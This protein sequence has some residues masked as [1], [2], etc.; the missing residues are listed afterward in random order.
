[1]NF[2]IMIMILVSTFHLSAFANC[3]T[4]STT[5][6]VSNIRRTHINVYAHKYGNQIAIHVCNNQ[7]CNTILKGTKSQLCENEK[8]TGRVKV[9]FRDI[10]RGVASGG[11]DSAAFALSKM[12]KQL[13]LDPECP[14]TEILERAANRQNVNN[15]VITYF[16]V[17]G[18]Y[19]LVPNFRRL[20]N[21]ATYDEERI[22]QAINFFSNRVSSDFIPDRN[23][24]S[25]PS[26]YLP[27]LT[28]TT[29][30]SII[31][32]YCAIF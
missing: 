27:N 17:A 24:A 3:L 31:T 18:Q 10:L 25:T 22:Q 15:E 4:D 11:A 1:M 14:A 30:E 7:S 16:E 23:L 9:A 2:Q 12:V 21:V 5:G 26:P 13:R 6:Y 19:D 28:A 29:D 32:Q 20:E 8:S